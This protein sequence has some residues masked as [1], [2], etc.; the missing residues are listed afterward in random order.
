MKF[1]KIFFI[2]LLFLLIGIG[3][4]LWT[5][6]LNTYRGYIE[7]KVSTALG[8]PVR[9]G[10]LSMKLSLIPT[11]EVQNIQ[12][13][14]C[15]KVLSDEPFVNV[16]KAEVTVSLIPLFS[17]RLEIQNMTLNT[18][19]VN[20]VSKNGRKNWS[21]NSSDA[22][23]L[24]RDEGLKDVRL[25]SF[26]ISNLKVSY[27]KDGITSIYKGTNFS[28]KQMKVFSL[29]ANINTIPFKI[30]GTMDSLWD[31]ILKKPDYLFNV[32]F[33]GAGVL[34]KFSGSIGNVSTF[35]NLLLNADISGNNLKGTLEVFNISDKLYP[36]Q[37]FKLVA[38]MQGDTSELTV[39]DANVSLGNNKLNGRFSG[40]ISELKKNPTLGLI[41][42]ISLSDMTLSHF[43]GINPF[44]ANVDFAIS[45]KDG[46]K[47]NSLS[48][49][50]NRTDLQVSGK[51]AK[52]SGKLKAEI[53]LSSE[54]FDTQDFFFS[55]EM[56]YIPELNAY[57][58]N[59]N[60]NLIEDKPINLSFLNGLD[61]VVYI[62][63]PHLKV[64]ENMR[65][66]L[67]IDSVVVIKDGVLT[68]NPLNM[69]FLGSKTMGDLT[70]SAVDNTYALKLFGEDLQLDQLRNF[71]KV[72]KNATADLSI[73]LTARGNSVKALLASLNGQVLIDMPSGIIVNDWFNDLAE[74]LNEQKKFSVSRSTSDRESKILCAALKADIKDGQINGDNNIAIETSTINFIIGGG[75]NLAEE[76]LD[77]TMLPVLN[78]ENEQMGNIFKTVGRFIKITG[79]FSNLEPSIS[80]DNAIQNITQLFDNQSYQEYQMCQQVLGRATKSQL[81]KE[82][83]QMQVIPIVRTPEKQVEPVKD[84]SF[85]QQL[86]D[87]LEEVLQ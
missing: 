74:D 58:Q 52:D 69:T 47:L 1:L 56:F 16:D 4:F 51:L 55:E 68:V 36:A 75:V 64:S 67:G 54:F 44:D 63:M 53:S 78:T 65:G 73:N 48:L 70:I 22:P 18:V 31:F 20:L 84:N 23:E 15:E 8:T 30:S 9:I 13:D 43:W 14:G 10:S 57:A 35:K 72:L 25:D 26:S 12:M 79:P 42:N 34:A 77:L 76:V 19:D 80:L 32:E 66:Y 38:V 45:Q 11:I 82:A 62:Q 60:R 2:L 29:N 39:S 40:M 49:R 7:R 59:G 21:C 27:Q 28:L 17:K 87:S 71:S 46:F 33:D 86:M 41:G 85:R 3:I 83:K 61:A 24:Q 6:D 37:P 81:L 5:F 50:A